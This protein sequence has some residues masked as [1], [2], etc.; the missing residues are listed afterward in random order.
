MWPLLLKHYSGLQT[1]HLAGNH[2]GTSSLFVH[3][4]DYRILPATIRSM[5]LSFAN[6]LLSLLTLPSS[7]LCRAKFKPRLRFNILERFPNLQ[8][9]E[10]ANSYGSAMEKWDFSGFLADLDGPDTCPLGILDAG[11][12]A[13]IGYTAK[14]PRKYPVHLRGLKVGMSDWKGFMLPLYLTHL[15]LRWSNWEHLLPDLPTTLVSL[16]LHSLY[17]II[18]HE[19]WK[20][21]WS[22]L[23]RLV[24]LR[25]FTGSFNQV[26][27]TIMSCIPQSVRAL[28]LGSSYFEPDSLAC[29]P[30]SLEKLHILSPIHLGLP[31]IYAATAEKMIR[32]EEAAALRALNTK[33]TQGATDSIGE[34]ES[35]GDAHDVGLL[36]STSDMD[37]DL[38]IKY[39]SPEQLPRTLTDITANVL[40]LSIPVLWKTFPRQL[41]KVV[42]DDGR[43]PFIFNLIGAECESAASLP[44]SAFQAFELSLITKA[45]LRSAALQPTHLVVGIMDRD[46]ETGEDFLEALAGYQTL[47]SLNVQ[48]S[49]SLRLTPLIHF[50][51][52][53]RKLDLALTSNLTS[54]YGLDFSLPWARHLEILELSLTLPEEDSG[55]KLVKLFGSLP[56]HLTTLTVT[57]T[58]ISIV[59]IALLLP[60]DLL[61]H[62]P[63][64]LKK[65]AVAVKRVGAKHLASLPKRLESA[66]LRGSSDPAL[67]P[68]DLL[69]LPKM[70]SSMALPE[71]AHK[72]WVRSDLSD[73]IRQNT[74][75]NY[76]ASGLM[77]YHYSD[78][79]EHNTTPSAS[80]SLAIEAIVRES[81]GE[82][83][84]AII[85][86]PA[87]RRSKRSRND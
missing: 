64:S 42:E 10:W 9:V 69:L 25:E 86:L 43:T 29:L 66:T 82:A 83:V 76:F 16:Q 7:A 60:A 45:Q 46:P 14:P 77:Q 68:E 37:V 24:N 73:W 78:Y 12:L 71:L 40:P 59:N 15:T 3:N 19:E 61:L 52:A 26:S 18:N 41:Q 49:F 47:T 54:L 5:N 22:H 33:S 8:S 13:G 56:P 35:T 23:L 84:Q 34:Q 81:P 32:E 6:G 62:L 20:R 4:V 75:L 55:D 57:T 67:V 44:P 27:P 21:Q 63:S 11:L 53:L 87:P 50:K 65:L 38:P 80:L 28:T 36:R 72:A 85:D 74:R 39:T 30:S 79:N 1:L 31:T 2:L 70:L 48:D 51:S 58:A 17:P